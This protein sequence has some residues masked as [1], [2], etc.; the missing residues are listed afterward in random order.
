[1]CHRLQ[2]G[3]INL[4]ATQL[5]LDREHPNRLVQTRFHTLAAFNIQG[6]NTF[7]FTPSDTDCTDCQAPGRCRGGLR[8]LSL[9][10]LPVKAVLSQGGAAPGGTCHL[11][12][13][14]A[15]TRS[16]HCSVDAQQGACNTP[17]S[18]PETQVFSPEAGLDPAED[19]EC[20]RDTDYTIFPVLCRC[21]AW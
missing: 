13:E 1:M 15:T 6:M 16:L 17:P 20:L 11:A 21:L 18:L 8:S 4:V 10:L 12:L 5:Q 14:T 3:E 7:L 9:T 2:G 19:I